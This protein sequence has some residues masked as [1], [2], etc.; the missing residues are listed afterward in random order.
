MSAQDIET[1]RRIAARFKARAIKAEDA[2]RYWNEG[3]AY[4]NA[5]VLLTKAMEHLGDYYQDADIP[6]YAE[7]GRKVQS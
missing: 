6:T 3:T 7:L 5:A 2:G 1:L 4:H